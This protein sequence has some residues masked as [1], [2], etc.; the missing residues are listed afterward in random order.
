MEMNCIICQEHFGEEFMKTDCGH[1]FHIICISEWV[2]RNDTCPLCRSINPCGNRTYYYTF[3]FYRVKGLLDGYVFDPYQCFTYFGYLDPGCYSV[4][5]KNNGGDTD[6]LPLEIDEEND[7]NDAY[8]RLEH[9][10]DYDY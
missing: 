8:D 5:R 3:Y 4:F 10:N 9:E 6:T 1:S 2:I 7:L